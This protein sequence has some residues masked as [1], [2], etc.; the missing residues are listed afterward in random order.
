MKN[1][2]KI[3]LGA[4]AMSAVL[5]AAGTFAWFTTTDKVEN[6]FNMDN[7]DVTIT[8][9]F[10]KPDVPL[11]PGADITKEVG[12]TNSGNVDVLVRVKLEEALSLLTL[13]GDK[14][15]VVESDSTSAT[16]GQVAVTISQAM[17]DAYKGTNGGYQDFTTTSY[18][19]LSSITVLRKT[20]TNGDNTV[21][22]Y[23]AYVTNES[24]EGSGYH[25]LVTVTPN[26]GSGSAA[27]PE[28]FTVKYLY[29]EQKAASDSDETPYTLEG[30]HGASGHDTAFDTY[31]GSDFHDGAVTLKFA[32]NVSTNGEVSENTT[33]VLMSDGYFYY[34]KAL[35]G[36]SISDPLLKS[37]TISE[38]AGNALK[39]ATYTITPEMQAVQL[40]W[41]AAKATWT[42]INGDDS[43]SVATVTQ[44]DAGQLVYNIVET[45]AGYYT[46]G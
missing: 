44:N 32:T 37:V 31:Y 16:T 30:T 39:G 40:D 22:S 19:N 9:D 4:T 11:T 38:S 20:T 6:V 14:L 25:H 15:K 3:A 34:T 5:V 29:N 45:G 2:K 12:V 28:S 18:D 46:A 10:D 8:E 1:K 21:Y 17:I 35:K 26:I 7:F 33:W 42:E 43:S 24:S 36:E 27:A 13:D 23:L 41:E